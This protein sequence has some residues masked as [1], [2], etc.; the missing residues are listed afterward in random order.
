MQQ[1]SCQTD[2]DHDIYRQP[3]WLMM[4][5]TLTG[6]LP[7]WWWS[8][9][10]SRR[11]ARLTMIMTSTGDPPDQWWSWHQQVTCQTNDDHDTDRWP[12]GPM[13]IMTSTGDLPDQW[14]S[15]HQQVTCL[16][17]D[18]HDI[19][20]WPARPTMIM[21]SADDPPSPT[22]IM[23]STGDLPDQWWSW[24]QQVTCLIDDDHDTDR[25]P[26]GL[27]IMTSTCD[28]PD[29]WWSWHWQVTCRTHDDHDI[30]RWPAGLTIIASTADCFTQSKNHHSFPDKSGFPSQ[31]DA[32]LSCVN[33]ALYGQNAHLYG[34]LWVCV[35]VYMLR[36][37]SMD[38]ILHIINNFMFP[39]VSKQCKS[40]QFRLLVV[41]VVWW[42]WCVYERQRQGWGR[43]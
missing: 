19:D 37:V 1:A 5:M 13:M 21:T 34:C 33:L 2:D 16:T 11:L 27:M 17:D 29:Q 32:V 26:A 7:D 3:T 6:D 28:M 23:T 42:W 40:L 12:A 36:I 24:H 35:R 14:L 8:W 39:C 30:S 22:L 15:W 43:V 20:R 25:W 9:H 31:V 10:R 18:D 4:I 41:V 38:K